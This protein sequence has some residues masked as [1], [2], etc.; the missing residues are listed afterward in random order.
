MLER[1]LVTGA[2]G[3]I[4]SR[5]SK[6]LCDPQCIPHTAWNRVHSMVRYIKPY[7]IFH[8]QA[9][10]N[11]WWQT[12]PNQIYRVNVM[13]LQKLM[14]ATKDLPYK[15]FVV[16]GSVAEYGKRDDLMKEDSLCKPATYYSA[17]KLAATE[18]AQMYARRLDKP[19]VVVRLASIYGDGEDEKRFIPTILRSIYTG[20]HM[21]L[22]P[23]PKHDWLHVDDAVRAIKLVAENADGLKG[24]VVNIGSGRQLSNIEM[25]NTVERLS[26][27][28]TKNCKYESLRPNHSVEMNVD[29]TKLK[30]L[31]WKQEVDLVTGLRRTIEHYKE[32]Y[33]QT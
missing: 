24:Q 1:N 8:L 14:E 10:G 4:G 12:D 22:D 29:I 27:R 18:M 31:G 21:K 28:T 23:H 3:F 20:E 9:Y 15:S 11:M 32:K 16:T 6:E 5:L 25:I 30:S 17:S 7:N 19:I 13:N 2:S 26:G 33:E